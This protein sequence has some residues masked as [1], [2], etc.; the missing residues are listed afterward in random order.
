MKE[1]KISVML[2]SYNHENYISSA[3]DSVLAQK[4]QDFEVIL[5]DDCSQDHTKEV[6]DRYKDPRIFMHFFEENQGA[7]INT[8]YVWQQCRGKY[9]ALLNS[10]DV[11]LPQHL[12]KSID[13]LDAH[14]EC[15]AVFS[16][17][18]LIDENSTMIDPC[19]E[20]F[21][22][23][24]R[25]QAEWVHD[26]FTKGNCLCHPSMVIRR[27]VYDRIGFYKMGFRQLP[28]FN[29]W[30]RLVKDSAIHILEEVLV[31]HRRFL[32]VG[33]N[34]SA[35]VLENSIRDVN[36]SFYTLLHYFDNMSDMLFCEA[37]RHEFRNK[38]AQS[39]E[40]FLCEKFFLMYDEKYYMHPVSKFAS[41]LFLHDI[42]DHGQV[43]EILKEK[44]HFGLA[45]VH[46][47]GEKY[48]LIGLRK[49]QNVQGKTETIKQTKSSFWKK[50]KRV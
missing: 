39:N 5:S 17:A 19:C 33:E 41:F 26:L 7:T 42:Y 31:Q 15:A 49:Q 25:T 1:P 37:F 27:E 8:K 2:L 38:E 34:T 35:P 10:D 21:R 4:E 40:E 46:A 3:I 6:L 50:W 47:L 22:Q 20:V 13:Y 48:D 14:K 30:V 12:T 45:E 44:Y 11:W 32:H 9:L 23:Q 43:R 16:W 24:N 29:M 18:A 28:D 36:E